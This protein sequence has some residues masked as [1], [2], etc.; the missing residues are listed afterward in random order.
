MLLIM[1]PF[2]FSHWEEW[3]TGKLI[4]SAYGNPTEAQLGM[5]TV[6]LI[7]Y[8]QGTQWWH[9]SWLSCASRWF[10]FLPIWDHFTFLDCPVNMFVFYTFS[11][12][13]TFAVLDK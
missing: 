4:L 7:T 5:C 1:L 12:L 8:F 2:Y 13:A 3:H 9:Q 11:V 6:H 10:S